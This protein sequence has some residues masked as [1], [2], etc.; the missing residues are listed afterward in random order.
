MPQNKETK[1]FL[2]VDYSQEEL[3]IATEAVIA[4]NLIN[5]GQEVTK[6]KV[7]EITKIAKNTYLLIKGEGGSSMMS[8]WYLLRYK[9]VKLLLSKKDVGKS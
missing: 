2:Q 5:S 9:A 7:A 8:Y 1:L 6:K 4:E 3:N